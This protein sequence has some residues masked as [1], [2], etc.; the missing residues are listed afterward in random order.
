MRW[1]AMTFLVG[2]FG[3]NVGASRAGDTGTL[4]DAGVGD[5]G[6]EVIDAPPGLNDDA[7]NE[8]PVEPEGCV[9]EPGRTLEVLFVGN[10]QIDF[11]NM[12]RL[13][14]SLSE[15]APAAC[16]RIVGR[17]YTRGGANLRD[18]W[19]AGLPG[20]I[21]EGG[22]DVVVITESIDLADRRPEFPALFT[23]YATRIVEATRASGATPILFATGYVE[24]PSRFG[25]R[26]M[27]DPQLALGAALEVPVAT[28]GLAWLRAWEHDAAIDLYHSDRAHP[29]FVGSYLSALVIWATLL[30]ASPV[31]LTNAPRTDCT[32]GPCTPISPALAMTLQT[33]AEQ[34]R[35]AR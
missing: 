35:L 34:E 17:R 7:A 33:V 30:D 25:F 23:D 29:G 26:E 10:S 22:Y 3:C 31:G 24:T 14:S 19:D 6:A 1:L 12:A 4:H 8:L 9:G 18:L 28:G 11:W 32:D 15:S 2:T 13:V 5:V 20:A 27:A 16:P 21:R